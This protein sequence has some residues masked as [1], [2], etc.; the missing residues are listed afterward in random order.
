[1]LRK[2]LGASL[3]LFGSVQ[4]LPG[5]VLLEDDYQGAGNIEYLPFPASA[6]ANGITDGV[7][8]IVAAQK[9]SSRVVLD[10]PLA[11]PAVAQ[12]GGFVIS[13]TATGGI[14]FEEQF[15]GAHSFQLMLAAKN[16][17]LGNNNVANPWSPL[18]VS[19][20]GNGRTRIYSQGEQLLAGDKAPT[21]RV[22]SPND[23]RLLVRTADF[24]AGQPASYELQVNGKST[25]QGA[26]SWKTA[27]EVHVAFIAEG[28]TVEI[29]DLRIRTLGQGSSSSAGPVAAAAETPPSDAGDYY[30]RDRFDG[31]QSGAWSPVHFGHFPG[32]MASRIEVAD[33]S[34]HIPAASEKRS[35][36]SP[37]VSLARQ[38]VADAGGFEVS[39]K[40]QA[41]VGNDDSGHGRYS[42]V[43]LL[44][45][46]SI[47]ENTTV[48]LGNGYYALSLSI[49][50]NGKLFAFSQ[51]QLQERGKRLAGFRVGQENELRLVVRAQ[52]FEAGA[53]SSY[54]LFVNGKEAA[55]GAFDWKTSNDLRLGIGAE[56]AGIVI[57]DF[58]IAP[59]SPEVSSAAPRTMRATPREF[60]TPPPPTPTPAVQALVVA[61][62]FQDG[63]V[64]QR[65][66]PV[67]LWDWAPQGAE[68]QIECA[69]QK[70]NRNG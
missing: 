68:I 35:R 59:L 29:D 38:E 24:G 43:L 4:C 50:G 39:M 55:S 37:K 57:D 5:A 60:A 17:L 70:T 58:T 27:G 64:L 3:V 12:D 47:I 52:S 11:S 32:E 42:T 33:G 26:F 36:I 23:I 13:F 30:L 69:G 18:G 65:D 25:F 6:Q 41:G 10:L 7:L 21:F 46:E 16:V 67:P 62:V 22:N 15:H 66:T 51:G 53:S 44:G 2:V 54:T 34:Y 48:G 1:M 31:N 19:V 8:R 45:Q 63:M 20:A 9:E 61:S 56:N 28:A 14:G 40:V 49:L